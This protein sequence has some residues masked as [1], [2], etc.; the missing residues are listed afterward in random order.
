MDEQKKVRAQAKL[1]QASRDEIQCRVSG[2]SS[3]ERRTR[4]QGPGKSVVI[5][6]SETVGEIE[7]T[8]IES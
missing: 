8:R 4:D 5:Q 1:H 2:R 6:L 7:R 3:P